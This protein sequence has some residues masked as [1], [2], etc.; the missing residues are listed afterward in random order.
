MPN[1]NG[2]SL[3]KSMAPFGIKINEA[4]AEE[5]AHYQDIVSYER[6]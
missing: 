3:K 5:V 6:I 1:A 2:K 4:Q